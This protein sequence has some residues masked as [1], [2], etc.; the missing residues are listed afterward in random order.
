MKIRLSTAIRD[1]NNRIG[2]LMFLKHNH[3]SKLVS[4]IIIK[5]GDTN[6]R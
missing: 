2:K 5:R 6:D 1:I 3:I 4:K